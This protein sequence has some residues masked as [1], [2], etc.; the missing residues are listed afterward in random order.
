MHWRYKSTFVEFR[1]CHFANHR[2]RLESK[3][4]PVPNQLDFEE[5]TVSQ[6]TASCIQLSLRTID[7]HS[8]DSYHRFA[9]ENLSI[10]LT[11]GKLSTNVLSRARAEIGG[12]W[13]CFRKG[14]SARFWPW[15]GSA[16][17][18]HPPV[19]RP[20]KGHGHFGLAKLGCWTRQEGARFQDADKAL[21]SKTSKKDLTAA[22]MEYRI[23]L[24]SI[25]TGKRG[26][27]WTFE[28]RTSLQLSDSTE[29]CA[30]GKA[31]KKRWYP[32]LSK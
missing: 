20:E 5:Y 21:H 30:S 6:S 32:L 28:Q 7:W 18:R 12:R 22:V 10:D 9:N 27:S 17:T 26:V 23:S 25:T 3:W 4:W 29:W 19:P 8:K 14:C 1:C 13:D 16:L 11:L 31:P 15:A 24:F 2:S